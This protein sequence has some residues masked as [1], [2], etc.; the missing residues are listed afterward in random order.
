LGDV[1][2]IDNPDCRFR[3][4]AYQA[5]TQIGSQVVDIRSRLTCPRDIA[6]HEAEITVLRWSGEACPCW[7][8]WL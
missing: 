1:H 4:A 5:T 6:S 7:R 3:R 8:L 2:I